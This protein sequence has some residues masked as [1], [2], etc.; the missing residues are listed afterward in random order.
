MTGFSMLFFRF[1]KSNGDFYLC[2]KSVENDDN[3]VELNSEKG[4]VAEAIKMRA[5]IHENDN[6]EI[7]SRIKRHRRS[8]RPEP[9]I[10]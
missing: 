8:N 7:W 5:R 9:Q 3:S 2:D 6:R 10:K 4:R 1:E